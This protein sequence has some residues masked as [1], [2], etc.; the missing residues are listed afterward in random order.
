MPDTDSSSRAPAMIEFL[1]GKAE[2]N[3]ASIHF[4]GQ[5][6]RR[7]IEQARP[8]R[9]IDRCSGNR[10]VFTSGGTESNNLAI[11]GAIE[12]A[13]GRRRAVTSTIELRPYSRR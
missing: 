7:L 5:R 6:A 10:L 3:P 13:S 4:S 11:F 12:R 1:S 2:G 8:R 9:G